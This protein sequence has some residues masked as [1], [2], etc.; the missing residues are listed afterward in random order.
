MERTC[1]TCGDTKELKDF[2]N[3]KVNGILRYRNLCKECRNASRRTGKPNTGRFKVGHDKGKRFEKGHTP[4]YKLKGVPAPSKGKSNWHK[5][6]RFTSALYKEWRTQ[7]FERDYGKCTK[8]GSKNLLAAHHIIPWKDNE[9]LRF[10]ISNGISLCCSCHGK[11]EGFKKGHKSKIS[12]ESRERGRLKRIGRKFSEEHKKKMSDSKKGKTPVNKGK[13]PS[14]ETR[15]KMSL[16]K[17][18]KPSNRKKLKLT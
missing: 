10:D 11:E 18:G 13:S 1:K 16:A 2:V 3:Q 5:T 4:W 6:D 14:E 8:C 7:V 12:H 15:R 17:L 9:S